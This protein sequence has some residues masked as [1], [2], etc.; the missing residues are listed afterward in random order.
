MVGRDVDVELVCYEQ[1]SA[2]LSDLCLL[3]WSQLVKYL[4]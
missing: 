1:D 3:R 4:I 2:L